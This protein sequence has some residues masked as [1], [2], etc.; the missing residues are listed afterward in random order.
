VLTSFVFFSISSGKRGVYLIPIFPATSLLCADALVRWLA[1]RGQLPTS[2][3][4][5]SVLL[6]VTGFV[7]GLEGVFAS[8]G[9]SFLLSWLLEEGTVGDLHA[10]LLLAF[11]IAVLVV[12]VLAIG[13]WIVAHRNRAP[14]LTYAAIVIA[15]VY[16]TELAGITLAYPALE[17]VTTIRPIAIAA[18]AR[19]EPGQRIGLFRD[20]QMLG[21]LAYYGHRRVAVLSTPDDVRRFLDETGGP[22]VLKKRKLDRVPGETVI[23]SSVRHGRRELVVVVDPEADAGRTDPPVAP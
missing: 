5:V 12:C 3:Q 20:P 17:P 14:L 8:Q 21:G 6:L 13:A 23:V 11:G 9:R 4:V 1:G 7:L 15:A 18:A 2:F 19:T 10:N 22:V 16:G